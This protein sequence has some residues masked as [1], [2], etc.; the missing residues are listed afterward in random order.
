[1][2]SATFASVSDRPSLSTPSGGRTR[3]ARDHVPGP[4]RP[5]LAM[6]SAGG[7][8]PTT[9]A[10]SFVTG[11]YH[12]Y[13]IYRGQGHANRCATETIQDP[14][15]GA[16]VRPVRCAAQPGRPAMHENVPWIARSGAAQ[17]TR[18][19]RGSARF[20]AAERQGNGVAGAGDGEV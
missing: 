9:A 11:Q 2:A 7:I 4:T 17:G 15:Q 1:M 14:A 18:G 10:G 8:A 16:Q 19:C 20:Y 5:G 6:G 13:P 12:R 3:T